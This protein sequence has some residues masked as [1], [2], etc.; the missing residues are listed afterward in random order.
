MIFGRPLLFVQHGLTVVNAGRALGRQGPGPGGLGLEFQRV[1]PRI[2]TGLGDAEIGVFSLE[3]ALGAGVGR[4][5]VLP[6]GA[7][8]GSVMT[9]P[10]GLRWV[11]GFGGGVRSGRWCGFFLPLF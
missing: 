7:R 6:W 5:W 11:T 8:A 3:N 2:L 10:C 4:R 9:R 1:K